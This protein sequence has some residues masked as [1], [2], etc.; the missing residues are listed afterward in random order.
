MPKALWLLLIGMVI[1]VTGGSFLWPLNTIYIHEHLGKS[2]SFAGLILMCN[3]AAGIA[4]NLIGGYLFDEIGGYRS[5][6]IGTFMVMCSAFILVFFHDLSSYIIVLI[7]LGLGSGMTFPSMYAMAGAVW[8][9]GGRK[10]FN[11]VYVAQNLGVALGAALGGMLASYKFELV[12]LGN[13][14]MYFIFLMIVLFGFKGMEKD[15]HL[16]ARKSNIFNQ[17]TMIRNKR[18][19]NSLLILCVGFLLCWIAYVQ[20]QSTI[21]A[22]TQE[23]GISLK[24]YSLL[25]TINGALIVIGQPFIAFFVRK[26]FHTIKTQIIAGI[27]L[28]VASLAVVANAEVFGAFVAAMIILT[29]GEMFVWPAVP[30]A[31]HELAPEGRAGFYQGIVNSVG[32][33]GRMIGPLFGGILVDLYGMTALFTVLMG[34]VLIGVITTVLYDRGIRREEASYPAVTASE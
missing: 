4:G 7:A 25:W 12:F 5:I 14:M 29:F 10:A 33:A 28:F 20:W 27:F 3:A 18:K 6:L 11:R 8:P 15:V 17:D 19:F 1:N 21:S 26:W 24:H 31:A 30:T 32:T 22:Y 16:A 34:L 23:I 9:E 13:G 2:L